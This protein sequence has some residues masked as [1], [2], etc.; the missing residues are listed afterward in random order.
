M[1]DLKQD[2]V[3]RHIANDPSCTCGFPSETANHYFLR[4]PLYDEIR[5]Q[6][7]FTLQDEQQALSILLECSPFLSQA[8]NIVISQAVHQFIK[9]SKRFQ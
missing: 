8:D 7:I 6:T 4:C 1:S 9:T 5:N 2:M 3:N